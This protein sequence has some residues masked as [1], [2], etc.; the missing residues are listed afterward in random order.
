MHTA[1]LHKRLEGLQGPVGAWRSAQPAR[2]QA[3]PGCPLPHSRLH[4]SL[5]EP[6]RAVASRPP[7]IRSLQAPAA[8]DTYAPSHLSPL[9]PDAA[10]GVARWFCTHC[11]DLAVYGA[12][13]LETLSNKYHGV[14]VVAN[15]PSELD[16]VVLSQAL[17][18]L[19]VEWVYS[20]G[21]KPG[22]SRVSMSTRG[23][24][25]KQQLRTIPQV[26]SPSLSGGRDVEVLRELAHKT[27]D[28]RRVALVVFQA[29]KSRR[30]SD[31]AMAADRGA[32][33][34]ALSARLQMPVVPAYLVGT[35]R[36]LPRGFTIP[37][38][39]RAAVEFGLPFP[40]P[41]DPDIAAAAGRHDASAAFDRAVRSALATLHT[42]ALRRGSKWRRRNAAPFRLS[43]IPNNVVARLFGVV[44]WPLGVVD[45]VRFTVSSVVDGIVQRVVPRR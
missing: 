20:L 13:D 38:P 45:A 25:A 1:M 6:P 15:H 37:A 34:A 21:D 2:S 17:H 33:V 8:D 32:S 35:G 42:T 3:W 10:F 4:T 7:E 14:I 28:S 23:K 40:V 26:V 5:A 11:L 41:G 24:D 27:A 29:I 12:A 39:G 16:F 43:T 22:S 44:I 30:G 9:S 36:V 31:D 19:G 18:S